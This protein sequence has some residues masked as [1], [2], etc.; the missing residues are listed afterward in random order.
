MN[1]ALEAMWESHRDFLR[2]LLIGLSRDIDLADDLLQETYL[3]AGAGMP[4]FRGDDARAWLAAIAKNLYYGH[5][6]RKYVVRETSIELHEE[7]AAAPLDHDLRID[8][9]GAIADLDSTSRTALLMKHYGGFTYK[10][11]A[12]RLDCPVGTAKWRVSV[13]LNRLRVALG[14]INEESPD[15]KCSELSG[16]R[17]LDYID[18]LLSNRTNLDPWRHTWQGA[19]DC[20][21]RVEEFAHVLRALDIV[22]ADWKYTGV[23]ELDENGGFTNYGWFSIP[24]TSEEPTEVFEFGQ[25][26]VTY[27]TI[28]GRGSASRADSRRRWEIPSA[29]VSSNP[30]RAEHQHTLDRPAPGE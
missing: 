28:T 21:K 26:G 19:P 20:R 14:V 9:R 17:L 6:R 5:L 1:D 12:E 4:G 24:N 11:I 7:L 29:A 25:T 10:D 8:V 15:M 2:R 3:R 13:A 30:A 16:A 23:F 22:E 18:G 27:M